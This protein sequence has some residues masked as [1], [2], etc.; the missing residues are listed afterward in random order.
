MKMAYYPGCSLETTATEYNQSVKMLAGKLGTEL[1]EIPDWNCCGASSAHNTDKLL[2]Y[3]LP[4]RN[5]VK[6]EDMG[7][8]VL[9]PCAAC[10]SR[11]RAVEHVVKNDPQ[12]RSQVNEAL[13]REFK[14]EVTSYSVLE[15]LRDQVGTDAIKD[16]VVNPLNGLKVACYYGCLLVRPT[17]ITGFDDP[18]HPT[19][20][21]EITRALG[22]APVEW[23]YKTECCG[24]GLA[25]TRP[26]IGRKLIHDILADARDNGADCIATACPLCQM[27]LDMRQAETE[28]AFGESFKLPVYY[29]TELAALA[30][31]EGYKAIGMDKHFVEAVTPL[32]EV[33][34]RPPVEE[35]PKAKPVKAPKEDAE[36]A[37]AVKKAEK[38]AEHLA[39][40]AEPDVCA[41]VNRFYPLAKKVVSDDELAFK[42]AE[43]MA[44][45]ELKAQKIEEFLEKGE[46]KA[47]KLA[48]AY[49]KKAGVTGEEGANQ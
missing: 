6:A 33:K 42:L 3:A 36:D 27:N 32:E 24:A 37:A 39:K 8:D 17:G 7:L 1:A 38:A 10:F 22:A 40:Q 30:M 35:K 4:A 18:E 12:V 14:A 13:G 16:K 29:I 48:L 43:L 47:Q 19:S 31:G 25:T 20:M 15:W 28:K 41:E 45:D 23:S 11:F 9:V 46:D 5:L 21:D 49:L 34:K 26:E 44:E 2:S